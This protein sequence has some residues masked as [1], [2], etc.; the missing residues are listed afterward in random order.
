MSE[1]DTSLD[2]NLNDGT[3]AEQDVGDAD[4]AEGFDWAIVEIFGHRRH[5]GKIREEERFGTKMLRIDV[6]KVN[7]VYGKADSETVTG[8]T[9]HYYG[10]ASIFSLTLSDEASVLRAN[11]PYVSPYR[12]AIPAPEPED[13]ACDEDD[14]GIC[15]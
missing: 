14:D 15:F 12:A 3:A 6:P 1:L 10:G 7:A 11:R 5:A 13:D 9:T 2:I 8:W 4:E